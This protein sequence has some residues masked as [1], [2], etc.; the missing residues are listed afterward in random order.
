LLGL[1]SNRFSL[2]T[3]HG[4]ELFLL[5]GQVK[6]NLFAIAT[7][8]LSQDAFLAW[9]I[10][11]ADPACEQH[12]P[13]LRKVAVEF[14]RKLVSLQ[15]EAPA[16]INKI[17]VG[18]QRENIDVWCEINGSY[19]L[20]IEDKVGSGQ[21]SNQLFRYKTAAASWCKDGQELICIYIKTQSD[22][23]G[24]L[25]RVKEQGFA[26]FGRRDVLC[27]L[28]KFDVDNDIYNDF[29]D[30]LR[31][32]ETNE[33]RFVRKQLAEWNRDDWKGFYQAL[34]RRRDVL[35][36]SYVSNPGGGFLSA[37]LN[38]YEV[39]NGVCAFM[40][41]EEG[42]LCFKIGEV[43]NDRRVIRQRFHHLL[44][45]STTPDLQ[46]RRPTR[47]G[48]G[49]YMTVAVV[50]RTAWLGSDDKV[51]DFDSTVDRL[52]RYE[53]WFKRVIAAAPTAGG[54]LDSTLSSDQNTIGL[55][56]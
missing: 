56:G 27:F 53:E 36:W 41:I 38:W 10:Q 34:E 46:L 26:V 32:I 12:N 29:R 8:E 6:P 55:I 40:Q 18:R 43:H 7:K 30:R 17:C 2:F 22:S 20:I 31:Q 42:N 13:V 37:V 21:H 25:R 44:M 33:S 3:C 19:F 4:N 16:E 23:A 48:S 11:W 45:T 54:R 35:N 15:G 9:L 14:V 39:S 5:V 52:N 49:K 24:N 28:E 47:F 1:T 51:P 50:P